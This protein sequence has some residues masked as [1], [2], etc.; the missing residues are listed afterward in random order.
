MA[1]QIIIVIVIVI[2]I[3]MIIMIIIILIIVIIIINN[4]GGYSVLLDINSRLEFRFCFSKFAREIYSHSM[5]NT[6]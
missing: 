4:N 3:I 6:I 2:M 5:L 1:D